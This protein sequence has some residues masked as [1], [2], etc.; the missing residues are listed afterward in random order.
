MIAAVI[1][2]YLNN[3]N[4]TPLLHGLV[5]KKGYRNKGLANS[6]LAHLKKHHQAITCF[7]QQELA[8]LYLNNGFSVLATAHLNEQL[9]HRYASYQRKQKTLVIFS[10][11]ASI[12]DK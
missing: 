8:P 2:S 5:V 3:H 10:L 11:T 4:T 1:I 6:L 12:D 9:Q 7:A